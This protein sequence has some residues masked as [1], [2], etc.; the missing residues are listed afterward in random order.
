MKQR[1]FDKW[2][3]QIISILMEH[4]EAAKEKLI[5]HNT[6]LS[7]IYRYYYLVNYRARFVNNSRI[8]VDSHEK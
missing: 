4:S 1:K 8:N 2:I 5:V 3:L 6:R 7:S